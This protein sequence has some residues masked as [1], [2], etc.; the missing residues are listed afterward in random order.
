MIDT[1]VFGD[2]AACLATA[3]SLAGVK[4]TV[5]TTADDVIGVAR[6]VP[7]GWEGLAG[8]AFAEQVKQAGTKLD[9]LASQVDEV[10]L[11]LTDFGHAL[12][13]VRSGI[14]DAR[15]AASAAGLPLTA[16]AIREPHRP[17]DE[18]DAAAVTAYNRKVAVYNACVTTVAD[19]RDQEDAAHSALTSALSAAR[20]TG[21]VEWFLATLGFIPRSGSD[22]GDLALFGA[23]QG[24]KYSGWAARLLRSGNIRFTPRL[25]NGQ[26][27]TVGD[28]SVWQRMW[29]GRTASNWVGKPYQ[30]ASAA[31][32]ATVGKWAG[33][34]GTVVA[35]AASAWGQW[36][37]DADDP[38]LNTGAKVARAATVGAATAAG[39]WAGAW[40]GAQV[41]AAIGTL[42]G[43]VGA[44]VGGIVGGVI[45]GVIGS[46]VGQAAGDWL[47]GAIGDTIG[48]WFD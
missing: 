26:F 20:H 45:G 15:G 44:A 14:A 41:G 33:R 16:D 6:S 48:S 31:R 18:T 2:P 23:A 25:P 47:K 21:P 9:D 35:F 38:S 46:G 13:A 42:G 39:G 30:G 7:D 27:R 12:A 36:S 28:M 29:A 17:A 1:R 43:P 11:A 24:L 37:A 22:G 5:E 4:S 34:A 32:W 8:E 3:D 10:R 19:R 40:A